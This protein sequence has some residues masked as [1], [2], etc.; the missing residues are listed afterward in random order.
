MRAERKTGHLS[1]NDRLADFKMRDPGAIADWTLITFLR[2]G[3]CAI[4]GRRGRAHIN[5]FLLLTNFTH[6]FFTVLLTRFAHFVFTV[7][8]QFKDVH[9]QLAGGRAVAVPVDA[10]FG[11]SD[12]QSLPSAALHR[13]VKDGS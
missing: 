6:I 10:V 12:C 4:A 11:Q 5:A 3:M 9:L 13:V 7:P 2:L 8:Q 1:L